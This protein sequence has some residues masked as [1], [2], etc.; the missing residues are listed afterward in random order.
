MPTSLTPDQEFLFRLEMKRHPWFEQFTR[1]FGEPPNLDDPDFDYR[2]AWLNKLWPEPYEF[3]KGRYHWP[4]ALPNGDMLK[5]RDHPTAWMESFMR[6]TGVDPN[7]MGLRNGSEADRAM[8]SGK[9]SLEQQL[10]KVLG[11]Y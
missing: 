9:V 11:R 3:D 10:G 6:S 8:M 5:S 7:S 1:D 2:K 4:S